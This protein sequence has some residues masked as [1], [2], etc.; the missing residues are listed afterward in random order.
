MDK[1]PVNDIQDAIGYQF[2]NKRL[3]QQAFVRS[4]YANENSGIEDNEKL[5]KTLK[6]L[7]IIY[8]KFIKEKKR[9]YLYIWIIKK[10][11]SKLSN[12]KKI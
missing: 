8:S 11:T 4:S 3:L 7:L 12:K 5:I 10:T 6:K 1:I 9:Y 2:K